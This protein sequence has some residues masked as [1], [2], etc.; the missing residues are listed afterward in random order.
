MAISSTG[1][2]GVGDT[3]TFSS[4]LSVTGVTSQ[5]IGRKTVY[6]IP[7]GT[8]ITV[9]GTLTG[10]PELERVVVNDYTTL[11][12]VQSG[13]LLN[14]GTLV[15]E[16]NGTPYERYS[17]GVLITQNALP[18]PEWWTDAN[19]ALIRV[20]DGGNL[21]WRGATIV[22]P[23]GLYFDGPDIFASPPDDGATS[24][25]LIQGGIL[26]CPPIGG[27]ITAN[28]GNAGRGTITWIYSTDCRI[29]DFR[30]E[31]G[32]ELLIAAEFVG[33]NGIDN[34]LEN[35]IFGYSAEATVY[36]TFPN[37]GANRTLRDVRLANNGNFLDVPIQT[38]D[39][40]IVHTKT[41]VINEAGGTDLRV[42]A[43]E[44]DGANALKD[45]NYG[46]VHLYRD[47]NFTAV[48]GLSETPWVGG[49]WFIRDT[50]NGLRNI[51]NGVDDT[52]DKT[53]S[54][55]F[56]SGTST[57]TEVLLGAIKVAKNFRNRNNSN[58]PDNVEAVN[59][60]FRW[61]LRGE[62]NGAEGRLNVG[63]SAG[64][65][66]Q[67]GLMNQ[68]DDFSE[69]GYVVI[70]DDNVVFA[71]TSKGS[72][73]LNGP[74]QVLPAV[75]SG[76]NVAVRQGSELGSDNFTVH[77]WTY[78]YEYAPLNGIS[79]SDNTTGTLITRVASATDISVT[80][81]R[82]GVD[83]ITALN[84]S[85][86]LGF[87]V[88]N[89][90]ITTTST[91]VTL[92][93]VYDLVKY[94]KEIS[95]I[96]LQIP[97]VS[98][99][100][101]DSD[102]TE[103]DLKSLTITQDTGKW[104]IGPTN[105]KKVKHDMALDLSK[106]TS[107]AGMTITAPTLTNIGEVGGTIAYT[108]NAT[109]SNDVNVAATG[110]VDSGTATTTITGVASLTSVTDDTGLEPLVGA[111][112]GAWTLG[113]S[114]SIGGKHSG[115]INA[116][117]TTA[118]NSTVSGE[119]TGIITDSSSGRITVS[120]ILGD[121]TTHSSGPVTTTSAAT[122]KELT[123]G[124]GN[125][126]IDGTGVGNVILGAGA[127]SVSADITGDL[128]VGNGATNFSGEVSGTTNLGTG[129][130][131]L[132]GTATGSLT[133]TGTISSTVVFSAG[134]T[135]NAGAGNSTVAGT[136]ADKLT[137]GAGDNNVSATITSGGMELGA[138]NNTVSGTI[139]GDVE[140]GAGNNTLSGTIT[141]DTEI[142]NGNTTANGT[143][144]GDLTTGTGNI[145]IG[146]SFSMNG[147][148][149]PGTGTVSF[150]EDSD[151]SNITL[152][153]EDGIT[154]TVAGKLESDFGVGN[155][156]RNGTGNFVFPTALATRVTIALSS[157]PTGIPYDL[158]IGNTRLSNDTSVTDGND[159]E[160]SN[161][162]GDN[163]DGTTRIQQNPI[164]GDW[165]LGLSD[166]DRECAFIGI[167]VIEGTSA[168]EIT[169]VTLT[170]PPFSVA[171]T[172][173][174]ADIVTAEGITRRCDTS[175]TDFQLFT[176][177]GESLSSAFSSGT[178]SFASDT[179][180]ITFMTA[181]GS[182][183]TNTFTA[184]SAFFL[185]AGTSGD[186]QDFGGAT[187]T[188]TVG[189]VVVSGITTD[190]IL[191][192]SV[193]LF[194]SITDLLTGF[195]IS[196]CFQ[197][198]YADEAM[199]STLFAG[200]RK[201]VEYVAAMR[202]RLT[203]LNKSIPNNG[204]SFVTEDV[205]RP[206]AQGADVRNSSYILTDTQDGVQLLDGIRDV[207]DLPSFSTGTKTQRQLRDLSTNTESD[208]VTH[209][210]RTTSRLIVSAEEISVVTKGELKDWGNDLTNNV[211]DS[212]FTSQTTGDPT[213][214]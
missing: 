93:D 85:I 16:S 204:I 116:T 9:N 63:I 112:K 124:A 209:R 95:E 199:T 195:N 56:S 206:V 92:D 7:A 182:S 171:F 149:T 166:T 6:T 27:L 106:F 207:L 121:T 33:T 132:S 147:T 76:I 17:V 109:T 141:G 201:S 181:I 70:G 146:F 200:A 110:T 37:R 150:R 77:A 83:G 193:D 46:S 173:A 133:T 152:V 118:T 107:S 15:T 5:E 30:M 114:Y 176:D 59:Q 192:A 205:V 115:A 31:L 87:V 191:G 79:L 123:A 194:F 138:G 49:R 105:H 13:G 25:I 213:Q 50:N 137:L 32:G 163:S 187:F 113:G 126:D 212:D 54:D 64:T 190:Q 29:E 122:F 125:S 94:K 10:N 169:Q 53:Y 145:S 14:V 98:T 165:T 161:V 101:I 23:I 8:T 99:L 108:N 164:A 188:R 159:L 180:A 127:S 2:Q 43:G 4:L 28:G 140:I 96:D 102:G 185:R 81:E 90:G 52:A 42:I 144:T 21:H 136:I 55:T 211:K 66:N 73:V 177:T 203:R 154:V 48:G 51:A 60:A 80:R 89:S 139:T 61:D 151:V 26:R 84:N 103:I 172:V 58:S 178:L 155:V 35:G 186:R 143:F 183:D 47:I 39:P 168:T 135:V 157:L 1:V 148:M 158:Y 68:P 11:F 91:D 202:R 78:E 62:S 197:N 88:S 104:L 41:K 111:T 69:S 3:D 82:T 179:S 22:A 175:D 208:G 196:G 74:D 184:G 131:T 40:V 97:S 19:R 20:R 117:A 214:L 189:N 44:N 71:Y 75:A 120:G 142:G 129:V 156:I 119:V 128:T 12:N 153:A 18:D 210:V 67:I 86:S 36:A 24:S 38:E 72:F 57:D 100:V 170:P 65:I 162:S 174:A 134:S 198:S 167:E 130:Q 34:S 45:R 160:Y